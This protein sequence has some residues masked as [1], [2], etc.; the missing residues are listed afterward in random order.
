[1]GATL[2]KLSDNSILAAG[3]SPE[4]DTYTVK[5]RTPLTNITAVRLELLPDESLPKRGPGRG[6]E[7]GKAVLTELQLAVRSPKTEPPRARFIR[8][9]LPGAQRVLSLAEV[10]V[11][12]ERENLAPKGTAR[13]SS[14]HGSAEAGRAIDNNTDGNFDAASTTMSGAQDNPWWEL[15]LGA[16][17][18]LEEIAIWNRT[19]RGLGT[20]LAD[21]KVLALDAQRKTVWER[22]INAVPS[23]VARFRVPAEKE[24]KL[25]NASADFS[26]SGFAVSRAVDGNADAKNGWGIGDKTGRAHAASFELG[27]N[28]IQEPDSLLIFTLVQKFGTQHTLGHFRISATTQ[29]PPVRELPENI[30]EILA[31]KPEERSDKQRDELANYFRDFAP[32]LVKIDERLKKLRKELDDIKPVALP[33]MRELAADKRRESHLLNKGNFLDP[34]EKV[35]PGVP[36]SFHPFPKDAPMNRFGLAQCASP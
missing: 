18:P 16:D 32:S 30:K 11:F 21:F 28:P 35:E 15:D 6:L 24:V 27:G 17:T 2:S 13:Q 3:N 12:D 4:R 34:G 22:N 1:E 19:D 33:V 14:T 31:A 7:S 29:P 26:E 8:I 25:Q 9:E 5:A 10:Q 36:A 23:P 20:R